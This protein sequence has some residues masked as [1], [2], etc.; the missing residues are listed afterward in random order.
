MVVTR[1]LKE[2]RSGEFFSWRSWFLRLQV[3]A[4]GS[5]QQVPPATSAKVAEPQASIARPQ[6]SY[7]AKVPAK[8]PKRRLPSEG[9][10][11]KVDQV[12]S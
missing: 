6:A 9:S 5:R 1:S 3:S 8:I 12:D 10:Q 4:P 7:H 2:T 11:A